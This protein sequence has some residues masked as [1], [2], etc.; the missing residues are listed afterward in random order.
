MTVFE[1]SS[2]IDFSSS[3]FSMVVEIDRCPVMGG[4][5]CNYNITVT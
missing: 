3:K 1:R 2:R 5:R 4:Q